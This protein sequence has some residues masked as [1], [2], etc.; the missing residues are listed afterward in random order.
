MRLATASS[1]R[2]FFECAPVADRRRAVG[3]L[4]SP[5]V[6]AS[7]STITSGCEAGVLD[8]GAGWKRLPEDSGA[9][10]MLEEFVEVGDAG[11]RLRQILG[12]RP[13]TRQPIDRCFST[14][15]IC[16]QRSSP[17]SPRAE[18]SAVDMTCIALSFR[19]TDSVAGRDGVLELPRHPQP[20]RERRKAVGSKCFP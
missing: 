11:G 5:H 10:R 13:T 17:V 16:A 20:T 19:L 2:G 8:G 6:L 18:K 12:A 4:L 7:I 14:C 3:L 1:I 15:R 9:P